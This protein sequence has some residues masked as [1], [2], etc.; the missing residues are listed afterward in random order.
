MDKNKLVSP[1]N[2]RKS[3]SFAFNGLAL[4]F[5]EPNAKIHTVATIVVIIAGILRHISP[6][7]WIAIVF[8][9]ALVWVTEALNTCIE[10][11]CDFCCD[12]QWLPQIKAIK[13]IA[14]GAVLISAIVSLAIAIIV[15]FL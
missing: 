15:F 5:T 12:N 11:L 14:A 8:A 13:D 10:R 9:I 2:T 6:S 7:Q 3:F 4:L 1:E